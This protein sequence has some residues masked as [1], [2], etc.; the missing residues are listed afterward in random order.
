GAAATHATRREWSA[1]TIPSRGPP[2]S[3]RPSRRREPR[4]P[5]TVDGDARPFPAQALDTCAEVGPPLWR[6]ARHRYRR[7]QRTVQA[8]T[9]NVIVSRALTADAQREADDEMRKYKS[10]NYAEQQQ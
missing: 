1:A 3:R 6:R 4:R 9:V 8:E 7:I 5:P 2:D 10:A